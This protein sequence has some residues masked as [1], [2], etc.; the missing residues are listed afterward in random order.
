MSRTFAHAFSSFAIFAALAAGLVDCGAEDAE[1]MEAAMEAVLG[2]GICPPLVP[3]PPASVKVMFCDDLTVPTDPGVCTSSALLDHCAFFPLTGC[4]QSPAASG[5]GTHEATLT[6]LDAEQRAYTCHEKLTVVDLEPPVLTCPEVAAVG[7]VGSLAVSATDNC[8]AA[9]VVCIGPNGMF[10]PSSFDASVF[11]PGVATPVACVAQDSAGNSAG[12][13]VSV[14]RQPGPPVIHLAPM[15]FE[16]WPP[17]HKPHTVDAMGDCIASITDACGTPI[18][19]AALAVTG[20]T[21]DEVQDAPG[22]GQNGDGHTCDDI[23]IAGSSVSVLA[24][25]DGTSNGRVYSIR[26]TA[27]TAGGTAQATCT[28]VVPHDQGKP[29][30]PDVD[31]GCHLCVGDCTG[32]CEG[33]TQG[34]GCKP[35]PTPDPKCDY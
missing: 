29:I 27:S 25:R 12:C 33:H 7:C 30:P 10:D 31:D 32:V 26:I 20:V 9:P 14:T 22:A 13:V 19:N 11:T 28:A 15:P 3:K 16:L 1:P 18:S 17:N 5:L 21:S 8:G 23:T 35:C 4:T 34:P 24:E 2:G 6:C